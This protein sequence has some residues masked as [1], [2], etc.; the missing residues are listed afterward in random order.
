MR[1][2]NLWVACLALLATHCIH[3]QNAQMV[4]LMVNGCGLEDGAGEFV[5]AYS[6]STSFVASTA[7]INLSY[8]TSSPA[9]QAFTESFDDNS[10]SVLSNYIA[11]IEA[12]LPLAGCTSLNLI[13][14]TV[15]TTINAGSHILII[16]ADNPNATPAPV[17]LIDLTGM[18]GILKD[19]YVF[20]STDITWADS[21]LFSNSPSGT[22]HL[23]ST[24]NTTTTN[25]TYTNSWSSNADGNY[26]AWHDGGGSAFI[27]ANYASCNPTDT[28]ILPVNLLYFK[29]LPKD[30]LVQIKWATAEEIEN[31]HFEIERSADGKTWARLATI[32]GKSN[33]SSRINYSYVDSFPLTG[34]SYYRLVQYDF[35][36]TSET[37]ETVS[38]WR[39]KSNTFNI[40]PNPC[41]NEINISG[42]L[43]IEFI[44][45]TNST[46]CEFTLKK[47]QDQKYDVSQLSPGLYFLTIA[48]LGKVNKVSFI[49]ND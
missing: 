11:S 5:L 10:T 16:N 3:A 37:F 18:C 35:S 9:N 2:K 36:G 38:V 32:A 30:K 49:K 29:A 1:P 41:R 14:G 19:V 20:I 44:T 17:R 31:S 33:S 24:I 13:A 46:G 45:A 26:A 6:G 22:R 27:Y 34:R 40:Y 4:S 42:D 21:G 25:F 28:N 47:T 39:D 43:D 15:G 12:L 48:S 23:R 8:G 7:T